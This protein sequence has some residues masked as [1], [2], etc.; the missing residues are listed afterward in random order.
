MVV[1]EKI[2]QKKEVTLLINNLFSNSCYKGKKL[3]SSI[4]YEL[5]SDVMQPFFI[6]LDAFY[7]YQII[8]DDDEYLDEYVFQV[9]K[10]LRKIDNIFDIIAG[11]N[12]ILVR[13][14]ALK[15]KINNLEDITNRRIILS[16]IYDKY[17]VNGYIFHGYSG[18]YK[19]QIKN[20]GFIPEQYTNMYSRFLEIE[21]IF[22][23][24]NVGSIMDKDFNEKYTYFTDSFM[25]GC[26]YAAN[27][28]MYFSKLLCGEDLDNNKGYD[29][30]AYF[31]NDYYGCFNNLN[32][33][34]KIC[35]FND[36]EKKRVLKICYDQWKL[37]QKN[38]A[39]INILLLKRSALGLDKL[40][41]IDE[42]LGN[43]G[44][45]DFG[46]SI[47]KIIGSRN[48]KI[49]I[50]QRISNKDLKFVEIPN[51]RA[52][53]DLK[54]NCTTKNDRINKNEE[55]VANAYGS[56]SLFA[57][58]GSLFITVGVILTIIMISRGG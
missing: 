49:C 13:F 27:S 7:K 54:E 11:I 42:I 10:L 51:Y 8:I 31:K 5:T 32:K 58:V 20:N 45:V 39:G 44:N 40:D 30:L 15:L 24:H 48:N 9:D 2:L 3:N 52:I 25:M 35:K 56:A 53:I 29:E 46:E 21:K 22:E 41:D 14:C 33:V 43:C 17:I 28:P 37:L 38:S 50:I 23:R 55:K 19:D 1:L 57:I 34:M 12:R 6:L 36:S 26:Y 18:I 47:N 4:N 16:Y